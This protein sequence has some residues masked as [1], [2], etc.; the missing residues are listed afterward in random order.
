MKY[1]IM[2][3][4]AVPL[5]AALAF[6]AGEPTEERVFSITNYPA[7][8]AIR[9]EFKE[10]NPKMDGYNRCRLFW[11]SKSEEEKDAYLAGLVQIARD[12]NGMNVPFHDPKIWCL[13]WFDTDKIHAADEALAEA[14]AKMRTLEYL[15]HTGNDA[16][17]SYYTLPK[18]QDAWYNSTNTP[19]SQKE[20]MRVYYTVYHR[21]PTFKDIPVEAKINLAAF[22]MC[23]GMVNV[24]SWYIKQTFNMLPT[25][26]KRKLREQGKTFFVDEKTGAN[27]VQDAIDEF[28]AA[29]NA[30]KLAGL[31]ELVAKWN[32]DYE[33]VE[34]PDYWLT[35]EQ[36]ESLKEKVY[37]GEV[38]FTVTVKNKLMNNLGLDK[39]NEFVEWYNSGSN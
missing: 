14:G 37:Y 33:W 10:F 8:H 1:P 13:G 19:A 35:D 3:I 24:E 39:F 15:W 21:Y 18:I 32:P 20:E 6:G 12:W 23:R 7:V 26:L 9:E 11:Q 28:V 30:P 2:T 29:F 34:L 16:V 5:A 22:E 36:L 4:V 27:P 25:Y 31:K 38:D 17:C